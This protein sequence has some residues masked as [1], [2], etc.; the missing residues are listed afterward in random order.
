VSTA[1]CR[2]PK[3]IPRTYAN[4]VTGPCM[5]RVSSKVA[6]TP[7]TAAVPAAFRDWRAVTVLATDALV[8]VA[9]IADT[10]LKPF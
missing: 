4:V 10:V 3:A 1:I 5:S 9:I 2:L 8:I 7:A 6:T